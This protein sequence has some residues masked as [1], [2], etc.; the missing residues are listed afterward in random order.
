MVAAEERASTSRPA[1]LRGRAERG[2]VGQGVWADLV[3]V[4]LNRIR[5]KATCEDPHQY[6]EGVEYVFVGG[7]AVIDQG[8]LTGALPGRVISP[9][10]RSPDAKPADR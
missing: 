8:E 10:P 1:A 5:D 9:P 6:S 3:V 7:K 2:Q 4:D